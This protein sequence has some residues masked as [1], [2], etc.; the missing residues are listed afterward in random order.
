[1]VFSFK[2]VSKPQK[3][4]IHYFIITILFF[5]FCPV[6]SGMRN[7]CSVL[8]RPPLDLMPVRIQLISYDIVIIH[9]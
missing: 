6:Y 4:C 2:Y 5:L 8:I 9:I 1:M 7:V 3:L